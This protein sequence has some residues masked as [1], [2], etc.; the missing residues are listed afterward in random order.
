MGTKEFHEMLGLIVDSTENA[1]SGI[2]HA[3]NEN[4]RKT[5]LRNYANAHN[6]NLDSD[7]IDALAK[8]SYEIGGERKVTVSSPRN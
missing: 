8:C 7:D 6:I 1:V 4:A 3:A 2:I 5:A